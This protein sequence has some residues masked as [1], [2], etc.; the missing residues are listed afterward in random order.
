MILVQVNWGWCWDWKRSKIRVTVKKALDRM[1]FYLFMGITIHPWIPPLPTSATTPPRRR[2]NIDND[3][4]HQCLS[5]QRIVEL[6]TWKGAMNGAIYFHR[7]AESCPGIVSMAVMRFRVATTGAD[8]TF[9]P[10]FYSAVV[11]VHSQP[12][13]CRVKWHSTLSSFVD[14]S[15]AT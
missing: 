1:R 6:E 13:L 5:Q 9:L 15:I 3:G 11:A 4:P 2:H 7:R 8:A 10:L 14:C 12:I